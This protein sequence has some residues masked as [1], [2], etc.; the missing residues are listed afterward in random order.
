MEERAIEEKQIG[1]ARDKVRA[2]LSRA[3]KVAR[4]VQSEEDISDIPPHMLGR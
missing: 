3:E 4:Q 1:E 2:Q